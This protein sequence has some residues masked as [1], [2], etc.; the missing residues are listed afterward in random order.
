[1]SFEIFGK[2]EFKS[3]D[4][5]KTAALTILSDFFT[6]VKPKR[7]TT[8]DNQH[9][10]R[11]TLLHIFWLHCVNEQIMILVAPLKSAIGGIFQDILYTTC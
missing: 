6:E 11:I 8:G 1:M 9:L 4:A 7:F 3:E 2:W 10:I 5:V